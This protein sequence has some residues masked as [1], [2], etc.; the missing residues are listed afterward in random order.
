MLDCYARLNS[1]T[2]RALAEIA[3]IAA[4]LERRG[5]ADAPLWLIFGSGY[6]QTKPSQTR[7][8]LSALLIH[9]WSEFRDNSR[10]I[11]KEN[12]LV[13]PGDHR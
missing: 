9:T 3:T 2:E 8:I 6:Q 13:Q 11:Y 12:S 5:Y 7:Y 10:D 4:E 1:I